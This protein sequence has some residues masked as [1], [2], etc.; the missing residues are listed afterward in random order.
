MNGCT[1]NFGLYTARHHQL[2]NVVRKAVIQNVAAD[3][4]SDM[5]LGI[6]AEQEGISERLR[7][8]KPEMVFRRRNVEKHR[9]MAR[10]DHGEERE[11]IEEAN[12]SM[13][14]IREF[15]C[16]DGHIAH[17]EDTLE[18]RYREKPQK[19][20]GLQANS[21]ECVANQFESRGSLFSRWAQCMVPP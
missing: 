4:R 7:I 12:E 1:M 15:T 10:G 8:L 17:R 9:P 2:A 14:D 3:L 13:M 19:Y 21:S 16:P 18:I 6:A 5:H 20:A 11:E